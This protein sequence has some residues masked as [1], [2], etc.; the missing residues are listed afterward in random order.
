MLC[1]FLI[2]DE[3]YLFFSVLTLF[4]CVFVAYMKK[5]AYLCTVIQKHILLLENKI[6][7]YS[8]RYGTSAENNQS[9]RAYSHP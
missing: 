1:L 2:F 7:K 4:C 5:N 8:K 9:K 3:F 6:L